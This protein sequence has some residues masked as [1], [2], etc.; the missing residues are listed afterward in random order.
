MDVVLVEKCFNEFVELIH[1]LTGI[2]IGTNRTSMI[3]GRLRK[4]I[5]A[6]QLESYEAYLGLVRRDKV[7]QVEFINLVTTNETSFFRTPR[8][9]SYIESKF[10]HSWFESHPK[11]KF[12]VWSAAS[13]SGEEAHTIGIL[14]E[15]FKQKNPGFRY[16]IMGSDI[17]NE[18]VERCRAGV[19]SGRSIEAFKA[20]RPELFTRYMNEVSI[21]MYQA[22]SEVRSN[23]KFQQHNL[24]KSLKS[25]EQFD[26][27]LVRNV[28]IYFKAHDQEKVISNAVTNLATDGILVIGESESLTHIRTELKA[29]EPLIYRIAANNDPSREVA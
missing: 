26:L 2:T 29:C 5:A 9:W 20:T 6:L 3:E 16:Q 23:L 21:G 12:R 13:S 25:T 24:F 28:L 4:R 11:R 14:C 15:S 10:L 18:M 19:Y 27:I 17:S 7:E 22:S 1:E 8:I